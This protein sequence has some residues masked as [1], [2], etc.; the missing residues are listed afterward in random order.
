MGDYRIVIEGTGQHN[1]RA[2]LDADTLAQDLV[3]YLQRAGHSV[4]TATF[5]VA[6]SITPT[7]KEYKTTSLRLQPRKIAD[8]IAESIL[9]S[10]G[11][12]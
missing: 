3:D 7:G 4:H 6:T 2:P 9:P 10:S 1:N 8:V 12:M 11:N 5:A